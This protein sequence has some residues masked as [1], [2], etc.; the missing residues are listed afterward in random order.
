MSSDFE[1]LRIALIG[2]GG[3][4]IRHATA[5]AQM[6]RLGNCVVEIRA[7]CD[8]NAEKRTKVANLIETQ[9]GTRPEEFDEIAAVLA[10]PKIE[11]VTIVLPTALH[12]GTILAA[13][14]AGKHVL[15]EKPLALTVAACDLVVDA[16]AETNLV[17]AVSENYRR[18]PSNRA[19]GALIA[20]DRLGRLD[21]MFVRNLASPEP[22]VKPGEKLGDSPKWYR[23]RN[24]VG[25]Y[26][27]LELGVH[28]ADLQQYWFGDV[29]TVDARTR[30]FDPNAGE[31]ASEDLLTASFGF[32]NGFTT[33]LSFC[34]SIW[35]IDIGDRLLLGQH[36]VVSS[37][38]WHAWQN[39]EVRFETGKSVS[40]ET[41]TS[42]WIANLS[43]ADRNR[44]LP[45]GA[46]S[47]GEDGSVATDPLTYG[48]GVAIH[49]FAD[50]VREG[51]E[52]EINAENAR[53]SV[54]ICCAMLESHELGGPVQVN[55]V[56]SGEIQSGQR[57]LNA[58][59]GIS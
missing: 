25:G 58:A 9:G 20:D 59:I 16:V 23:D 4:G 55:R 15:V 7:L 29:Q 1:P 40:T 11:A 36:A 24:L 31:S 44:M 32:A 6:R 41:L 14:A 12:H 3:M 53:R 38:K 19:I 35:G 17:V 33:N 26:Q 39:G 56:L 8:S 21:T 42:E 18:I 46:F 13:L 30:V 27:V 5:I 50:A 43:P 57:S 2:C 28:E 10:D 22:P 45:D 54:A 47:M 51:R 34:S 48:V 37:N 52:P 49:D